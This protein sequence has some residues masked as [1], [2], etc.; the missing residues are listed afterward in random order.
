MDDNTLVAA[1]KNGDATVAETFYRR[2]RPTVE[3]IVRRLLGADDSDRDDLVQV[4]IIELVKAIHG[5]RGA[6]PL[7]SWVSAVAAHVV[8]KHIRRQPIARHVS[9][10]LVA[11]HR[12]PRSVSGGEGALARREILSRVLAHLDA[13]GEKLAWSFVLH[14]VLGHDLR[15]VA[16]LMGISEAAAQSRLVRGRRRLHKRISQDP[17]L[18]DVM[19]DLERARHS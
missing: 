6:A 4:A 16:Q 8:Y 11:E 7:D 5:Y 15:E 12:L 9:V 3:R 14:D 1:L 13:I 2:V 18:A 19:V 10:D 17:E